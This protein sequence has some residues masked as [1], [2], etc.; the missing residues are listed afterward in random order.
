M[1]QK[2]ENEESS[3]SI[4][5]AKWHDAN[6]TFPWSATME[7]KATDPNV[8]GGSRSCC[9]PYLKNTKKNLKVAFLGLALEAAF[10][11]RDN[12]EMSSE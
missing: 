6:S 9:W 5:V 7:S 3:C 12:A 10:R 1:F 8:T 11:L 4:V 2:R